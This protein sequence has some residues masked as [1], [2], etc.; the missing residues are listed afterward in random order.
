M[1]VPADQL[2]P[3]DA[4]AFFAQ[5]RLQPGFDYRDVWREEHATAFTVAKITETDVLGAVKTSLERA[6]NEGQSFGSWRRNIRPELERAGWWGRR[7]V[8]DP[9]TGEIRETDL[10]TPARLRTIYDTNIRTAN[11]AG[12]WERIQR[13]K[14][15]LPY[16]LYTVG[17]SVQH[18]P[19][20]LAWHGTLLP[21]DDPWWLTHFAPNGYGCKCSIRQ[22]GRAEY[23]KLVRD[24]VLGPGVQERDHNDLPTGRLIRSRQPVKLVAPPLDQVPWKNRRTGV[25][26]LVPKGIDPGFDTNPGARFRTVTQMRLLKDK[27]ATADE[28]LARTVVRSWAE[29][30]ALKNW[31]KKPFEAVPVGVV[32]D[33]VAANVGAKTRVVM[34]SADTVAK[35]ARVHPEI[36]ADDYGQ[37]AA[38]LERGQQIQDSDRSMIFVDELPDNYLAVVK[39]TLSGEG[40]FLTSFRRLSRQEVKRDEELRRLLRKK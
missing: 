3:R 6:L 28:G 24:G 7:E 17:P 31:L 16:L 11:S 21:A 8:A 22:V 37:V 20:H 40:L 4:L 5:K 35:Q 23:D 25:T 2:V 33:Q 18:R 39:S 34:L 26:G 19:E 36:G 1:S 27:L 12:Q 13:T 14:R 38:V 30:P 29:G 15:F 9:K 32:R 10:S